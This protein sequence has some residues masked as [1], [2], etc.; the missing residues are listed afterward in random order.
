[1]TKHNL[2]KKIL[3][4]QVAASTRIMNAEGLIDYSGHISARLPENYGF[5]IQSFDDSR[6]TVSPEELLICD[7]DANVIEGPPN[8]APPRE[9]FIHT[10][11]Y[12]DY[13]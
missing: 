6:A 8:K 4:C 12:M 9:I 7:F 3:R 11:I 13:L 1:M 5:L 2:D 10:E